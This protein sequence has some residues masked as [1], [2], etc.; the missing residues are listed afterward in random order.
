[1]YYKREIEIKTKCK[2]S[3]HQPDNNKSLRNHFVH[4][5]RKISITIPVEFV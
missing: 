1:M 5:N 3:G 2:S 4:N